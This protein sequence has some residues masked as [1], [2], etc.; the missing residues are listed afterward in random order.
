MILYN[1]TYQ[2]DTKIE[3]EWLSFMRNEFVTLY[4]KTGYFKENKI[5]RLINED[6][7]STGNTYAFQFY[8]EDMNELMDFQQ[9]YEESIEQKIFDRYEGSFVFFKTWL[10]EV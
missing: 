2:V 7:E 9:N 6:I 1:I 3:D 10:E 5:L 4:L 8:A